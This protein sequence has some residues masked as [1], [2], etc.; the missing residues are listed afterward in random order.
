MKSFIIELKR[1]DEK[2][3]MIKGVIFDLDGVLVST[4]EMHFRAWKRLADELGIQEFTKEDNKLQK[5][6]SRLES[7]E[8]VLRKGNKFFTMEE[9]EIYAELKNRYY[10]DMLKELNEDAI[11]KDVKETLTMLREKGILIGV[12]SVSKNTPMILEKT[13]LI[14][15]IDEVSCGL[16]I[17]NSKPD[18]EVFLVAAKK[19]GL[20][21]KT[22]LVVEDSAA[23]VIAAK[24]AG[25]RALGVGPE[26]SLL[27]A[28]YQSETLLSD[29]NW[30]MMLSCG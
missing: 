14:Q 19:L 10:I 1:E 3:R 4:D 23:G 16:D 2:K 15:W 30:D 26:R 22:C 11:L 13:G 27:K 17:K 8:V 24:A 12:G 9:K 7:L 25:M 5:G 21:P 29:T 28:D 18:P 6:V 20:T